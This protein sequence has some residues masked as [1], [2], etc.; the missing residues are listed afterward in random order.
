M[1][2]DIYPSVFDNRFQNLEADENSK[3]LAFRNGELLVAYDADKQELVY[4][5]RS[6]FQ[7]EIFMWKNIINCSSFLS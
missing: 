5:S 3:V 4:P 6:E 2:Q 1:V 7:K